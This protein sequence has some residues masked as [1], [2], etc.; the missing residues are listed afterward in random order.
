MFNAVPDPS[1]CGV[2]R[3]A[4]RAGGGGGW[5]DTVVCFG[6]RLACL[7]VSPMFSD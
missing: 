4:R 7:A 5:Y 3:G 1:P 2:S 6:L